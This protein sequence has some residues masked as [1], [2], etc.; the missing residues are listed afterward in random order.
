VVFVE[1]LALGIHQRI[2]GPGFRDQ[3][4]GGVRHRIA[5]LDQKFERVIEAGVSDWPSYEIGQSF[6]M[7]SP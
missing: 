3:H 2:A 6:L 5:A 1:S 7:S 4:H